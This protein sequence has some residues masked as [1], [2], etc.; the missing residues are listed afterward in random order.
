MAHIEH[1]L[2]ELARA[3]GQAVHPDE[4]K[5]TL[6]FHD[7][8][9]DPLRQDNEARS[10]D[11]A[12]RVMAQLGRPDDAQQRVRDMILAT[13]HREEPRTPDE[14]LVLDIDLSILGAE[15][16]IFDEYDHAVREEYAY[17]P[18]DAYREG[19]ARILE[20]FLRRERLFH[21]AAFRRYEKRARANIE[22]ALAR[23]NI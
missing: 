23:L 5:W 17:V 11:W 22:R 4:V 1:C 12:C 21:T 16:A 13:A 14:A 6:L 10:A 15:E 7:A 18:E 2:S 8:V 20:S 19:R 3:E 9:Y